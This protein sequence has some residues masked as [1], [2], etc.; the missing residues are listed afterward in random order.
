MAP[1]P[2][3]T[4]TVGGKLRLLCESDTGVYMNYKHGKMKEYFFRKE[5]LHI[6]KRHIN[7]D[8]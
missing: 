7:T 8:I 3:I 2:L 6:P 1:P 4:M 5:K